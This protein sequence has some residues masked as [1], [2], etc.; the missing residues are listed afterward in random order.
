NR[1]WKNF[2]PTTLAFASLGAATI[3][4]LAKPLKPLLGPLKKVV[5]GMK[6][7]PG[8][9]HFAGAIGTSVQSALSGKTDKLA[10]L[11]PFLLV[12]VELYDDPEVFGF[13]M[14][15]IESED[16]LWTWISYI[17]MFV[18]Q[19]G[20]FDS[21]AYTDHQP[22]NGLPLSF[23]FNQ[24]YAKS[25]GD[26]AK[27]VIGILNVSARK[28]ADPRRFVKGL[29]EV[30]DELLDPANAN[31]KKVI[32]SGNTL[33]YM[34]TLGG[35]KLRAFLRNTKN[36]RV[37]RWVVLFS[38]VYLAEEQAEGRLNISADKWTK[39][40]ADVFSERPWVQHGAMFQLSQMVYYHL[41]ARFNDGPAI[42]DIEATRPAYLLINSSNNRGLT[43]YNRR[44]DIVL[45]SGDGGE[46]WVETKSV[47]GP[48][49]N[50]WFTPTLTG[51]KSS[52]GFYDADAN[53]AYYRQFFHDMRLNRSIISQENLG[54]ILG[55]AGKSNHQYRWYFHEF[56]DTSGSKSPAAGDITKAR[57]LLCAKP[58]ISN[59]K[60]VYEL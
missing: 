29:K 51:A 35:A 34:T 32:L 60:R 50:Q 11:M 7:F 52:T 17:A 31:W 55:G 56:K 33:R 44:I 12:A 3:I 16:D 49:R 25:R 14:S 23:M 19:E 10:N 1:D 30:I 37:N 18:E 20:G 57:G 9:K 4:P 13:I 47:A 53:R 21:F 2:D 28:V 24:A 39:L 26:I 22:Q 59:I 8:A 54:G 58:N 5:D 41:N 27:Q 45:D 43:P 42:V 46:T 48:F 36:W 6:K 40:A 38:V 15:T